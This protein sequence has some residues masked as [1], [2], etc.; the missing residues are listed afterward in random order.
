MN[1]LV[2][3]TESIELILKSRSVSLSLSLAVAAPWY[4]FS[5]KFHLKT[6][7]DMNHTRSTY[8]R[9]SYS[10]LHRSNDPPRAK[11]SLLKVKGQELGATKR[12]RNQPNEE[13]D[14]ASSSIANPCSPAIESRRENVLIHSTEIERSK[15]PI[16]NRWTRSRSAEDRARSDRVLAEGSSRG[17]WRFADVQTEARTLRAW[18]TLPE[19]LAAE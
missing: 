16:A 4:S 17:N 9:N 1:D 7:A 11:C 19:A 8:N 13:N 5:F 18:G 6:D 2:V 3:F 12:E 10:S 15:K 14:R